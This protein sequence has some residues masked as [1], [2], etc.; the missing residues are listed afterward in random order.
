MHEEA[1]AAFQRANEL[2]DRPDFLALTAY[3]HAMA[4][5]KTEAQSMLEEL[6]EVSRKRY[7]SSFPIAMIYIGLGEKKLSF[8]WLERA[9]REKATGSAQSRPRHSIRFDP[10]LSSTNCCV[11][12]ARRDD[13]RPFSANIG[14]SPGP[15]YQLR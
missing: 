4:G 13:L 5:E 7:V 10:I 15:A 2:F 3:A 8:E 12:W 9:F 1:A 6:R 14:M 11:A